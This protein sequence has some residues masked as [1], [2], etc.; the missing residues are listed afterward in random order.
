MPVQSQ[1]QFDYWVFFPARASPSESRVPAGCTVR[2]ETPYGD[3]QASEGAQPLRSGTQR[4]R[5][6][7]LQQPGLGAEEGDE[8]LK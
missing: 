6:P 3:P 5:R 4:A 1:L 7:P 2:Q 8:I